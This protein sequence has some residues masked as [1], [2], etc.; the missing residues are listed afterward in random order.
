[1]EKVGTSETSI[2]VGQTT[3]HNIPEDDHFHTCRRENLKSHQGYD[4]SG[5]IKDREIP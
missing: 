3:R 2:K 1:M 5:S 4:P